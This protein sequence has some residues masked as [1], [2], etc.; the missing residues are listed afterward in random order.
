MNRGYVHVYT[1]D[2]KGKSTAAF[3][4]AVRAIGA[5]L[6][7]C[8]IQFIKSMD[9]HELRVLRQV[10]VQLHQFG[11]GCFIMSTPQPEDRVM[12]ARGATFA[13]ELLSGTPPDVLILDEINV[14]CQ[15]GLLEA[16]DVV[17]ILE[18]RPPTV[19]LICTGR[20]AP[21]E[22]IAAA[23]LVTEMVN[24]K[25]YFEMGVQARDGIER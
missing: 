8:V 10:G 2:G 1:G 17:R 6:S 7:V 13:R 23:D 3:G 5:G 9:Y 25:H 18:S 11:R 12:A 20:G 14:A 15:L 16:V 4:L 22:L 24:R 19:E 21:P